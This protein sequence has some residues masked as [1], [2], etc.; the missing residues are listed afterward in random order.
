MTRVTLPRRYI[1]RKKAK[2][3]FENIFGKWNLL[4]FKVG[5]HQLEPIISIKI[6]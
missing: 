1:R 2:D 4:H 5:Q 6:D 3:V